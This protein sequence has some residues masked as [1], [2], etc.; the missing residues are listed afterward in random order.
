M[1]RF[2]NIL[3]LSCVDAFG[4][5]YMFIDDATYSTFVVETMKDKSTHG[6]VDIGT[7]E[8]FKDLKVVKH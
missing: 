5:A 2:V 4:L 3:I 6:W 1:D 7:I 8:Y